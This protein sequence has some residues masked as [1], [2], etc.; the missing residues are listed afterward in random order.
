MQ[1]F[2]SRRALCSGGALSTREDTDFYRSCYEYGHTGLHRRFT[3]PQ[4]GHPLRRHCVSIA[5]PILLGLCQPAP[6]WSRRSASAGPQVP[7]S[8]W[9]S[10][11]AFPNT[12]STTRHASSTESCRAKRIW[13]PLIA[14][15]SNR[16]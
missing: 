2:L 12:G 7:L 4:K 5:R 9:K 1:A 11:V 13:S 6:F 3:A 15:R 10:G 16:S 8:Y 14:S